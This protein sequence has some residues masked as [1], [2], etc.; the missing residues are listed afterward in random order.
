MQDLK[1]LSFDWQSAFDDIRSSSDSEVEGLIAQLIR[2][3]KLSDVLHALSIEGSDQSTK[4]D[5]L[6]RIRTMQA[7]QNWVQ[8]Y[9]LPQIERTYQ[10]IDC[11]G[12]DHIKSGE[13]HILVSN[14]HDILMDPLVVNLSLLNHGHQIAHCAIGDNLIQSNEAIA[15]ASLCRC[16]KVVRSLTSPRAMLQAMKVQSA[17]INY[18]RFNHS[19]HIWIAQ[20]EGRS[21]DKIDKTN[22]AL[23]KML[24][25]AKPKS[26]PL[27]DFIESQRIV[28]VSISYEWDPCD[29]SKALQLENELNPDMSTK[30]AG[31]DMDDMQ[32]G[33]FGRKGAIRVSFG[34]PLKNSVGRLLNRYEASNQIDEFIARNS[35]VFASNCA[36]HALLNQ[37]HYDDEQWG[38]E[39]GRYCTQS[40]FDAAREE[41]NRRTQAC[42][43]T[44][45]TRVFEAYSQSLL[46]KQGEP[47]LNK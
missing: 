6:A 21:K 47:L 12:L 42:S 36:A 37:R 2:S 20:K 38:K 29:I 19:A 14:H 23:I 33:L 7:F 4:I 34:E 8:S 31:Q 41:L 28:P 11:I 32:Q 16:F 30:P 1:A 27:E 39:Y 9:A 35:A 25:L 43:D 17:Y 44:I 24:S 15:L 22:P 40:E 13:G 10:H 46:A 26:L 5:S 45:R 3:P 18:L